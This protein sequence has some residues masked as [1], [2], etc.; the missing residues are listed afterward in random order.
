MQSPFFLT[1]VV[2]LMYITMKSD[3]LM[4]RVF[5]LLIAI[6]ICLVMVGCTKLPTED[7]VAATT[8]PVYEITSALCSGTDIRV[9]KLIN[10]NVSCLHDYTLQASQMQL[11]EK[12]SAIIINGAGFESFLNDAIPADKTVIDA[13]V[14]ISFLTA[15]V[16][17]DHEHNREHDPHIWLAPE[18]A[19]AMSDNILKGLLKLF[20][21]NTDIFRQNYAAWILKLQELS[22]FAQTQLQNLKSN[23]LITFHDGFG[24]LAD[25]Y[26]LEIV[27][28]MEEE[29]GSEASAAE[30]IEVIQLIKKH[31]INVIFTE[32]NGSNSAAKIIAAETG[33][34]IYQ[35]DMAISGD[36]Y[37]KAMYQNIQVLKE[38]LE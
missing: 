19:I 32:E 28:S 16:H 33:A 36:S 35:L 34:Q 38:A 26:D 20:P 25:A 23:K 29:S 7:F 4:K 13:S 2:F 37:I 14:G 24:Y 5:V 1:D 17:E 21:Q 10:E 3:G 30:L 8:L 9:C 12:A 22:C 18:N 11:L 27:H 15:D 31:N 6:L